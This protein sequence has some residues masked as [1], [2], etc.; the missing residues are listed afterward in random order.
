[1]PASLLNHINGNAIYNLTSPLFG[2]L[3]DQLELEADSV[4]NSVPY[5]HRIAQIIL[6]ANG[7]PIPTFS[8]YLLAKYPTRQLSKDI[9]LHAREIELAVRETPIIGNYASTNI[10]KAYINSSEAI[11]HGAFLRNSWDSAKLG[12]SRTINP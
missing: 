8:P 2:F 4:E 10:V 9:K 1:M 6:E 11:I 7:G 3:V 12:V 5:D